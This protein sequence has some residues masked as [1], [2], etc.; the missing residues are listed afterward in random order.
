[1]TLSTLSYRAFRDALAGPG[2]TLSLPPYSAHIRSDLARVASGIYALYG[3]YP[4]RHD[5]AC[6]D[7]RVEVSQ[8]PGRRWWR[9]QVQFLF[10]GFAPFKP[11]PADQAHA[12]FEWGLNWC[13]GNLDHSHLILHAAVLERAGHALILPG[14]P[15][16]GK[17][18]LAAAL[19]QQG[20]RLLS[21]E[22]CLIDPASLTVTPVP[23]PVSLKNASI[24]LIQ[25]RYPTA[26]FSEPARDTLKGTVAHLQPPTAAVVGAD[27]PALPGLIVFPRYRADSAT[28]W[29]P[30]TRAVAALR[31]IEQSF[32]YSLLGSHGFDTAVALVAASSCHELFYSQLDEAIPLLA[33]ALDGH[34]AERGASTVLSA[35]T[36]S[37]S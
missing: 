26:V 11:L 33:S 3:D 14:E 16:A 32:N 35:P 2:V 34:A 20:F 10:D 22:M 15:G 28:V 6:P 8:P 21:D 12:M 4:I 5:E 17:S 9:P 7:F 29:Q 36:G 27:C 18:T 23:R 24:P 19:C 25:A 37:S 13:I 31:C 30:V 1:M